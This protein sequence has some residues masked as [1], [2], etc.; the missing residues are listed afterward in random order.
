VLSRKKAIADEVNE[1]A[2]GVEEG[3]VEDVFEAGEMMKLG[4]EVVLIW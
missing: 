2:E 1:A 4:G 3:R